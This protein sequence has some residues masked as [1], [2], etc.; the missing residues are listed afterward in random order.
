M[1][2]AAVQ[3]VKAAIEEFVRYV[4]THEP[5]T[6]LYMA[7][8]ERDDP[9]RFAHFFIFDDEAAQTAHSR[10][11]AVK[12]FQDVYAPELVGERVV[13]TNSRNRQCSPRT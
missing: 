1:N 6:R 8:Q 9:T 10:S 7:W 13:F 11:D 4:R 3:K 5:G 12:R 2:A